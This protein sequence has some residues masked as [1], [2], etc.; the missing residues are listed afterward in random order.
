[1]NP[2]MEGESIT[3]V[4]SVID[5]SRYY[6]LSQNLEHIRELLDNARAFIP[7][8]ERGTSPFS[9]FIETHR[10]DDALEFLAVA[11]HLPQ[12]VSLS[13]EVWNLIGRHYCVRKLQRI[14]N[15][16]CLLPEEASVLRQ[17]L[18]TLITVKAVQLINA[19][20]S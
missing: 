14:L 8:N 12:G 18:V 2:V 3:A 11:D 17:R 20:P 13:P 6:Q 15:E 9:E 7:D 1:M 10:Y 16:V 5:V 19:K 4:S